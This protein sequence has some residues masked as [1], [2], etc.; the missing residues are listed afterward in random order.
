MRLVLAP[1]VA[2]AL[3]TFAGCKP[4]ESAKPVGAC[5]DACEGRASKRCSAH[6]CSRGCTFVLDRLVEHEQEHVI[7]CV[8]GA[9][10]ACDDA[11]W[12]SCAVRVGEH[13]DGGPPAPPSAEE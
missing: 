5:I 7:A 3:V 8:A 9:T 4:S 11:L 13:A 6:E 1:L 2:L 10:G 12:A